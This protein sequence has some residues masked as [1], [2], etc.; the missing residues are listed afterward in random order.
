MIPKKIHYCWFG[1]NELPAIA[2]KCINSWKKFFPDYEIIE[3]NEK[4]FDINFNAY[5]KE[6][7]DA[8]KYAFFTDVARLYIIYNHGGIYFDIDVEVINS[9]EDVLK[10]KAFFG[11]ETKENVNTGL[12]FGAVPGNKIVKKMLDDYKTKKFI[13]ENGEFDLTPC[14]ITNSKVLKK[15]KFSLTGNFEK[16]DGIAIYPVDYFNPKGGYGEILNITS[17]T[18]S[19]HHF[20]GSWLSTEEKKRANRRNLL[21]IKYGEKYGKIMYKTIY[22]PFILFSNIKELGVKKFIKKIIGK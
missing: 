19:I 10:N 6:A 4:N 2:K 9:F 16:K 13:L 14:P 7:Y 18:L 15:N 3:W 17:N 11:F 12:G 22:F 1:G 8:K 5:A 21:C 20:D